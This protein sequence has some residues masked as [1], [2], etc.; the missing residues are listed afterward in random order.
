M[1]AHH[2]D[3]YG[4]F[5]DVVEKMIGKSLKIVTPQAARVEMEKFR[6]PASSCHADLKFSEKVV[7]KSARYLVI[8]R[9]SLAKVMLN[10]LVKSDVHGDEVR[11]RVPQT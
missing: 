3:F 11:Q 8:H 5:S 9:E 10:L 2:P 7:A 1:V 4:P 6:V